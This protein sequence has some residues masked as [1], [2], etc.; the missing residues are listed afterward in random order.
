MD[1]IYVRCLSLGC[2]AAVALMLY[3]KWAPPEGEPKPSFTLTNTWIRVM[4]VLTIMFSLAII[5]VAPGDRGWIDE[6]LEPLSN[7]FLFVVIPP[8]VSFCIV[9]IDTAFGKSED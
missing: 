1:W 2:G 4:S 3:C 8:V 5:I 9:V 7:K 6:I